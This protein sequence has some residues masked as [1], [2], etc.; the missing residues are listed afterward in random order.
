MNILDYFPS[1]KDIVP[2]V[3]AVETVGDMNYIVRLDSGKSVPATSFK[4][5]RLGERVIVSGGLI[6]SNAGVEPE[7]KTF[8][9]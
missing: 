8:H 7:I 4:R 1:E 2:L 5:Y 3:G 6:Q 9:V